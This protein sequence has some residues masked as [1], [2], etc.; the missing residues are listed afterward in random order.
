MSPPRP[1]VLS[2]GTRARTAGDAPCPHRPHCPA[3][4]SPSGRSS[5]ALGQRAQCGYLGVT[6]WANTPVM[7]GALNWKR[8]ADRKRPSGALRPRESP[9]QPAPGAVRGTEFGVAVCGV[10]WPSVAWR[11]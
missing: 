8:D 10:A 11:G 4:T 1:V 9:A 3:A 2:P 7:R 5:R 6:I